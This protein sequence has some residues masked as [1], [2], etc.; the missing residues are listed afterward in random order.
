M[1]FCRV[2]TLVWQ[3]S[4]VLLVMLTLM[5]SIHTLSRR[6]NIS[7][8]NQDLSTWYGWSWQVLQI[9]THRC[10]EP[11][12]TQLQI[13]LRALS[14]PGLQFLDQVSNG[15]CTLQCL[16]EESKRR[17]VWK[18]QQSTVCNH[19]SIAAI[20][21]HIKSSKYSL[22]NVPGSTDTSL[23][24]AQSPSDHPSYIYQEEWAPVCLLHQIPAY[25]EMIIL[26]LV[27]YLTLNRFIFKLN[28]FIFNIVIKD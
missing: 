11:R 10:C 19:Q 16:R 26:M 20:L 14:R 8:N 5:E 13:S 24:Y 9:S 12:R 27:K 25:R 4:R 28:V 17:N 1:V 22:R 23:F 3:R 18:Q 7:L 6:N 15:S 2:S 21:H